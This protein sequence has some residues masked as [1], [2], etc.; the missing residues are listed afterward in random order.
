MQIKRN[1]R[2]RIRAAKK[3]AGHGSKKKN[4]GSGARGGVGLSNIGKRGSAKL[5]KITKGDPHY[6]GKYGFKSMNKKVKTMNIQDIQ[7]KLITLM[8]EGIIIKD[9]DT[10]K[11]DLD[12]A[13]YTKLLSKGSAKIKMVIRVD[14]A[15][16]NAISKVESAG[17]KVELL[18][19]SSDEKSEEN[20]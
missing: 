13:G 12:K 6:L 9:K 20:K 19:S 10:F 14:T 4:R 1:K 15:T 3:T 5:M 2:S 11:V 17:G 16:E 7:D 8:N 18:S